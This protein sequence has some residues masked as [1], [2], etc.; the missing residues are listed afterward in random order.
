MYLKMGFEVHF[1]KSYFFGSS[2]T[3]SLNV[4]K[5]CFHYPCQKTK[6]ITYVDLSF[7]CVWHHLSQDL[8]KH[9][10]L[11]RNLNVFSCQTAWWC[12]YVEN[13]IEFLCTMFESSAKITSEHILCSDCRKNP[14]QSTWN[15]FSKLDLPSHFTT[16]S[17]TKWQS[18][19]PPS[20]CRSLNNVHF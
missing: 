16:I 15:S 3:T 1:M 13:S 10:S 12:K 11:Q 18:S 14:A 8:L 7:F 2:A 9:N 20:S 5:I 19:L 6:T 4:L 17:N